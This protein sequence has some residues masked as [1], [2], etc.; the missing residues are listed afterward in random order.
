MAR[1]THHLIALIRLGGN[2]RSIARKGLLHP[3][4]CHLCCSLCAAGCP[5]TYKVPAKKKWSRTT[6]ADSRT[7]EGDG[8]SAAAR[9]QRSAS[10]CCTGTLDLKSSLPLHHRISNLTLEVP[11]FFYLYLYF[12]SRIPAEHPCMINYPTQNTL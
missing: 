10:K 1:L 5:L 2:H 11:H 9:D 3:T 8:R 7:V 6:T 12:S 4:W